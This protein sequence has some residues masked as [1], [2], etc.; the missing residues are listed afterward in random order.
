MFRFSSFLKAQGFTR[1]IFIGV[2]SDTV[3]LFIII[4]QVCIDQAGVVGTVSGLYFG[5][6]Y[7]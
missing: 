6:L 1:L 5:D 3:S 7:L 2:K 4:I